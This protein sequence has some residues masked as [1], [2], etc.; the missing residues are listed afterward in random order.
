M[1]GASHHLPSPPHLRSTIASA[2]WLKS[3]IELQ[4]PTGL[5]LFLASSTRSKLCMQSS[6]NMNASI[7]EF[8]FKH[9]SHFVSY[10]YSSNTCPMVLMWQLLEVVHS[11]THNGQDMDVGMVITKVDENR[12]SFVGLL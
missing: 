12:N 8:H 3:F 11:S 7:R 10:Q 9:G 4:Q 1:V 6:G 2:A 5:T